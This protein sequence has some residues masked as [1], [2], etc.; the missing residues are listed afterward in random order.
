MTY[1]FNSSNTKTA[2]NGENAD[3]LPDAIQ[4]F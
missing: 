1:N 4:M 2:K 3:S